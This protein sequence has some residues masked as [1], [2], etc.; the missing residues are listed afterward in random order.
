M[1]KVLELQKMVTVEGSPIDQE[2]ISVSSCDS[3]SC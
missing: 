1:S 2:A 3:H